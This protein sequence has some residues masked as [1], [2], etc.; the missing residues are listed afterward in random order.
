MNDS[1]K[2]AAFNS[3]F[4]AGPNKTRLHL[5]E[6]PYEIPKEILTQID[7]TIGE[8]LGLY[9]DSECDALRQ[10]IANYVGVPKN[11]IAV[12]N[13]VDELIMLLALTFARNGKEVVFTDTTF[14]G[15]KSATMIAG[16][17]QKT[18]PLADY[19]VDS[20]ALIAAMGEDT[21]LSF[22]CNPLNPSGS[23][24]RPDE[25]RAIMDAARDKDVIPIFDEAYMEYVS[26]EKNSSALDAI[27]DGETAVVL[28]TFSKAW[29]LASLRIG[30]AFGPAEIIGSVWQT[31]N[32]L[33]FNVNRIAQSVLP[34]VLRNRH[35]IKNVRDKNQHVR[36]VFCKR[37][38]DLNISYRRSETNY[39][40]VSAHGDSTELAENLAIKHGIL[41]RDL[42]LFGMPGWLRVSIGTEEEVTRLAKALEAEIDISRRPESGMQEQ[43]HWDHPARIQETMYPAQ[44]FNG[45]AASHAIQTLEQMKVWD[46]LSEAPQSSYALSGELGIPGNL[47][48]GLI[49]TVALVGL[50]EIKDGFIHL[51]R[52]GRDTIKNMGYFTWGVGG[53]GRFLQEISE[54]SSGFTA[55]VVCRQNGQLI[56]KGAGRVGKT[57]MLPIEQEMVR[58]ISFN[59]VA[60]VGCGDGSRLIRLLE[61]NQQATAVGIDIN[62]EA[63]LFARR[64]VEAAGFEKRIKIHQADILASLGAPEFKGVDLVCCFLMMHDLFAASKDHVAAVHALR[65]AFPDATDFLIADTVR[66]EWDAGEKLPIFSLQFEL[67]HALSNV[68]LHSLDQYIRSFEQGGMAVHKVTSFGAPSTW[69]FHL[70]THDTATR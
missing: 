61:Q 25:V 59:R 32:A 66:Q 3:G 2:L 67:V 45:F 55:P 22:V 57:Q 20:T 43:P 11:M 42:A 53:Y 29:G 19:A 5:N 64:E 23:L 34:E 8:G 41:V 38:D 69:L 9:P 68:P 14:P 4:Q 30:F 31:R 52:A 65:T 16:A 21:T 39:V 63:V 27:A 56:A 35:Y 26:D 36:S 13:G 58:G 48:G 10:S 17:K 54:K 6:N 50:V 28:R 49:R 15:Y 1:P 51:T 44:I 47:L 7:K 33:P 60:D 70:K 46:R 18:I 62:S 40:M 37:L 12:G 24:L